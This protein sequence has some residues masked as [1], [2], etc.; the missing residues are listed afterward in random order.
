MG[1]AVGLLTRI[2]EV[3]G[4]AARVGISQVLG[5]HLG[6]R[7]LRSGRGSADRF[8]A[9]QCR[10]GLEPSFLVIRLG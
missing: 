9:A 2:A 3:G 7:R 1:D 5:P 8:D 6:E 4:G 10:G